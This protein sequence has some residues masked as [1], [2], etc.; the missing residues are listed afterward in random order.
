MEPLKPLITKITEVINWV[1]RD[2]SKPAKSLK[3]QAVTETG[4][5]DLWITTSAAEQLREHLERILKTRG[6]R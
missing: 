5:L 2:G 4:Q 3:I 1:R 6:S